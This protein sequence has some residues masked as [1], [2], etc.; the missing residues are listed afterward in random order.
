MMLH[1]MQTFIAT[2]VAGLVASFAGAWAAFKLERHRKQSE[3][4]D[5]HIN[6]I[7]LAL[8]MLAQQ[9]NTLLEYKQSTLD[10]NREHPARCIAIRPSTP[11]DLDMLRLDPVS[12]GFASSAREWQMVLPII[13]VTGDFTE[14]LRTIN[15]R[16]EYIHT[17]IDQRL[18]AA[19]LADSGS[20]ATEE[21]QRALGNARY[22]AWDRK[23]DEVIRVV[24][25]TLHE[26]DSTMRDFRKV[27]A[28]KF[29][30]AKIISPGVDTPRSSAAG[31]A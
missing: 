25:G 18:L 1:T 16:S 20:H 19:G 30:E 28:E 22:A 26:I 27:A 24:D 15:V 2:L 31:S 3:L 23:T 12:L 9:A 11:Y 17:E 10:P 5:R 21:Y 6:A 14:A 4:D 7:N 13:R 29:G 8:V